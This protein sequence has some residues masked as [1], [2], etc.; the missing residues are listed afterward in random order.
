MGNRTGTG[1]EM[2]NE[3]LREA[4]GAEMTQNS[5]LLSSQEPGMSRSKDSR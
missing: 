3:N 2:G 4:A 1:T 5:R